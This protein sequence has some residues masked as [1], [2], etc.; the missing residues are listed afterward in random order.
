M[1]GLKGRMLNISHSGRKN[2]KILFVYGIHSS[3]ERIYG[4]A[5]ALSDFGDV[6][7]P[8]LPGFG[9]MESFYSIGMKPSIDNYADYLA[10]FIKL[11][12]KKQKVTIAGMSLGFVIVTR[13]LQRYPEMVKQV[14]LLVS[15]VGF[16][17]R[18]DIVF[19]KPRYWFYRTL[20]TIFKHSLTA[21]FF[22]NVVLHPTLIR[23]AYGK[24]HNAKAKFEGLSSEQSKTATEFEVTLWRSNDVRTYMY[25]ILEMFTLNNCNIQVNLSVHHVAAGID[26]Y[27]NIEV[28]EQHMRVIFNDYEG[29]E[30]ILPNHAPSIMADKEEAASLIPAGLRK[31]LNGESK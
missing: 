28:V 13:M 24:T 21:S 1:N 11:K 29:E 26:Q 18:Y 25:L 14:D 22:H 10:S 16:S 19:T 9:G 6:T 23:L 7:V 27:F 17:H 5:D 31:L 20:A 3:L 30:A 2:R 4:I 12:Y 8:D 15:L